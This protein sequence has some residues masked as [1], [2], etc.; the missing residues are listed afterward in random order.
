MS[1]LQAGCFAGALA[2]SP[3]ADR[4][5]RKPALL[6]ANVVSI[7]GIT[8]QFASNGHLESMYVG[9]WELDTH[10]PT[11][12]LMAN[13]LRFIAGLG[14]GAASMVNP[15]YISENAPRAIRGLLTGIY[16]LFNVTGIMVAF[17]INY[18]SLLHI[19]GDA[20]WIIPLALQG[21][22]AVLLF[23]GMCLCNES[24]R[25]LAKQDRWEQAKA[26]LARVRALPETHPYVEQEFRDISIQLERE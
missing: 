7:V 21:L 8:L 1:T 14:C 6:T 25:F 10:S 11:S 12:Y 26:V 2:A 9:R 20:A 4:W 13:Q 24:P 19:K 3:I 23:V 18:G 5:G 15:L 16:Q 17:W 22:P